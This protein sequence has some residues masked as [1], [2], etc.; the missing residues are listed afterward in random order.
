[1]EKRLI[2]AIVFSSLVLLAWSAL[3]PKPEQR[4]LI[5]PPAAISSAPA[6]PVKA[7]SDG[8]TDE[9]GPLV[10]F[11]A[12]KFNLVFDEN[13]AA[14]KEVIFK[15][16]QSY[17]FSLA[18]GLASGKGFKKSSTS[19]ESIVF[20]RTDSD[21]IIIKRF[22]FSNYNYSIELEIEVKNL[23]SAPLKF[24]FPLYLGAIDFAGD[25]A[26]VRNF[27]FTVY[28]QDKLIHPNPHK[29]MSYNIL[30]FIGLRDRYFCIITAPASPEYSAFVTKQ[31]N[32]TSAIGLNSAEF[33]VLPGQIVQQ[34]FQ[35]Y[36][37]PQ[38]TKLIS[39]IN[40]EWS[41]IVHFGTF[42]I[43]S[44]IL[45]KLLEIFY[46]LV[47]N[48][49]LAIVILSVAVYFILY[50]L[51]IKQMRSMKEMQALQPRIEELRKVYKDNPQRLNKEIM[52]LY[53]E[54]KVNP[55]GGCLPLLLQMPIFFA[56]YQALLRSVSLKGSGFLWIKDL[57]EPDKLFVLPTSLPIL[58][59]EINL[60]PILMM[61]GM[62]LQQKLTTSAS[63][64]GNSEQQ[65]IMLIV[66]PL[67]FG[68]IFYH[69]P[70]GLVLY[71][72]INSALMLLFQF[73][74]SR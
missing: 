71:W 30:K 39:Q 18:E 16:Y 6:Q 45:L 27:D 62:F 53:R 28:A 64:A 21:K 3:A 26:K 55:L 37:G 29:E 66:F 8:E 72:F 69:M 47:H 12:G 59:N 19:P 44:Q 11:S 65:K 42:D 40:P 25:P 36:L 57:S 52:E 34:K 61:I 17:K 51:S 32:K 33:T 31:N 15:D 73:K 74:M 58:G 43:I 22:I 7:V 14:I 50:P 20:S 60:L 41:G 70:S 54:H 23:S 68:F 9:P 49:G 67:M 63:A 56:L 2:L 5:I 13:R 24:S 10:D 48:W 35:V 1:M 38:E 46:S 4:P